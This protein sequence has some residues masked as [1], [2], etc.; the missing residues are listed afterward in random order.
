MYLAIVTSKHR[1][2]LETMDK[3][4]ELSEKVKIEV[5]VRKKCAIIRLLFLYYTAFHSFPFKNH[6]L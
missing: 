5:E 6:K 1:K 4:S 3:P 2:K